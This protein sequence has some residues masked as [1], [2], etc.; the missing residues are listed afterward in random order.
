[1]KE[2]GDNGVIYKLDLSN[3]SGKFFFKELMRKP[4]VHIISPY[5]LR[6]YLSFA[7]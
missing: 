5:V 6:V 1:M 4:Y 2:R 3:R 7:L